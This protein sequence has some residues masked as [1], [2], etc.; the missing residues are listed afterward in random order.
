MTTYFPEQY[1]Y[2]REDILNLIKKDIKDRCG[3]TRGIEATFNVEPMPWDSPKSVDFTGV[4]VK[5]EIVRN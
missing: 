1:S 3:F 4:T 2:D 5:F